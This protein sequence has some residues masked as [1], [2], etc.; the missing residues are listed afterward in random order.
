MPAIGF[1]IRDKAV[2][3]GKARTKGVSISA[4]QKDAATASSVRGLKGIVDMALYGE[5]TR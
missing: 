5:R 1:G 4:K 3:T 2:A